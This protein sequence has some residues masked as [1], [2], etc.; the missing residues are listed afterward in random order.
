[1]RRSRFWLALCAFLVLT[2][3]PGCGGCG[4]RERGKNSD[5]DRPKGT[6]QQKPAE[7]KG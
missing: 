5:F 3:L 7:K 6:E 2:T 4:G 1:V